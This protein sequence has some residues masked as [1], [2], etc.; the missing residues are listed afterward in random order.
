[1]ANK[2]TGRAYA[3]GLAGDIERITQPCRVYMKNH[4]PL[5]T[6]MVIQNN[7]VK[8]KPARVDLAELRKRK[9]LSQSDLARM[10]GIAPS[11]ICTYEKDMQLMPVRNAKRLGKI[12][13]FYW[14]NVYNDLEWDEWEEKE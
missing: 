9:H 11:S 8:I 5:G 7:L 13:G 6:E 1:M 12:L 2:K 3:T 10:S 4:Y 14:P